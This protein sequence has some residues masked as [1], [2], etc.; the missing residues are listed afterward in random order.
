MVLMWLQS[1]KAIDNTYIEMSNAEFYVLEND[2]FSIKFNDFSPRY[3]V[4]VSNQMDF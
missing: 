3:G 1:N 2:W 4:F